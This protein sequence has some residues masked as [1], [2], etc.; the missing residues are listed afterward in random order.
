[1]P[2]YVAQACAIDSLIRQEPVRL[3]IARNYGW[4]IPVP[5]L[6]V[7]NAAAGALGVGLAALAARAHGRRILLLALGAGLLLAASVAAYSKLHYL[8]NPII[9]VVAMVAA[10]E[11]AAFASRLRQRIAFAH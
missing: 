1:M 11:I 7:I 9:P 8:C 5:D 3:P 10:A 6:W 4:G 2:G